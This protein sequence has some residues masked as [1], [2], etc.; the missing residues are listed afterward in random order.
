MEDAESALNTVLILA[1]AHRYDEAQRALQALTLPILDWLGVAL[2][3]GKPAL[4]AEIPSDIR[5]ATDHVVSKVRS[6]AVGPIDGTEG[7]N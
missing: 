7:S 2:G 1:L 4:S 5:E 3:E 6:R